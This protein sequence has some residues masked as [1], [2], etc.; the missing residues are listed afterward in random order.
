LEGCLEETGSA[1]LTLA[2]IFIILFLYIDDIVILVRSPYDIEKKLKILKDFLSSM[3][4]TSNNNKMRVIIIKSKN[5]T[6]TNF[7]YENNNLEEVTS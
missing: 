3:V 7:L 5:I 6:Y 2:G 4:M 1:I